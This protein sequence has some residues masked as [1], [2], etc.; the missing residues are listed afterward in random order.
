MRF[1]CECVPNMPNADAF[2]RFSNSMTVASESANE[3]DIPQNIS[4]CRFNEWWHQPSHTRIAVIKH[5][6][7]HERCW[8]L[9]TSSINWNRLH[10]NTIFQCVL[11]LY[12]LLSGFLWIID[13]IG[14]LLNSFALFI[15]YSCAIELARSWTKKA[16]GIER[17]WCGCTAYI[18][19]MKPLKAFAS[20]T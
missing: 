8:F 9:V 19:K 11:F 15:I 6:G 7:I 14:C 3:I 5:F 17:T 20:F 13:L 4:L 12:N 1:Q 2:S 18:N 16:D 10:L